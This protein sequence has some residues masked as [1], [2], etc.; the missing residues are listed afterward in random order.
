MDDVGNGVLNHRS[1][2]LL[3]PLS[4]TLLCVVW[5]AEL[6]RIA[7][8]VPALSALGAITLGAFLVLACTRA[9]MHIRALFLIVVGASVAMA[10]AGSTPEALARGFSRAQIFGAFLP[11]VLLLRAT[12]EVSPRLEH[13]RGALLQLGPAASQ[14]WTLYGS[15]GL[16]AVLNVGA[17][18]IL[19]PVATRDADSARRRLLASSAARGV[20]TAV[21]WSPF[22]VAMAF[23]SHLVPR[24][25]IWQVMAIGAGLAA[26]GLALSHVLYTPSLDAAAFRASVGQLGPLLVPMLV[27]V[28]AVVAA[29]VAF[30]LSGLQSVALVVPVFCIGY[31]SA[32]GAA[33]ARQAASRTLRSFA[34]LADELLIVVG[35]TILAAVVSSLPQVQSLGAS[36]TPGMISGVVLMA[37]LV[38]VLVA[39]GVA[40]LHPMIGA[41][42]LLP[43]LAA[44]AFGICDAVLVSTAIFAWGLSASI[45]PWTLPVVAASISFG[46][47]VRAMLSRRSL[48]FALWY[49]IA[50]IVYLGAVNV[51]CEWWS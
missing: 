36:V 42:I 47:P 8:P 14:N 6:V 40:G 20:G 31:L 4:A 23:T 45:S 16:G 29:S 46:V 35:A 25:A 18:A 38:S 30:D 39:L 1:D 2:G 7:W 48:V 37:A 3:A 26:I 43:V 22:F 28:S 51:A 21:M 32:L 27:I 13:L 50:G 12:V 24:T 11:S 49:A 9:S 10:L 33:P 17:M 19:A 41:G 44:G 34:Q 5:F 15:H